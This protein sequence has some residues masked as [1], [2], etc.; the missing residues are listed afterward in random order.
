MDCFNGTQCFLSTANKAGLIAG[1]IRKSQGQQFPD[2]GIVLDNQ[3]PLRGSLLVLFPRQ[4][5]RRHLFL[6][7]WVTHFLEVARIT[8]S[9]RFSA[10]REK[11][12]ETRPAVSLPDGLCAP[13]PSKS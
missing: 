3:N 10:R 6:H 4:S 12:R 2:G 7:K 11:G 8:T 1:L 13:A 5:L 9:S